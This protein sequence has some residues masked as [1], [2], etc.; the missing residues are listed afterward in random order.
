MEKE[1]GGGEGCIGKGGST[2]EGR[3]CM[4][5]VDWVSHSW[6]VSR[7]GIFA[8]R[9]RLWKGYLRKV[10]GPRNCWFGRVVF[11]RKRR[12]TSLVGSKAEIEMWGI[13]YSRWQASWRLHLTSSR[14]NT[15]FTNFDRIY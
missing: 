2:V 10:W 13:F 12:W 9:A 3:A 6:A 15:T 4:R 14:D 8:V 11:S 7:C 5:R 1:G